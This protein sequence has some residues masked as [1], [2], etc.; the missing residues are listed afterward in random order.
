MG[1]LMAP[2]KIDGM[3]RATASSGPT[4]PEARRRSE[5]K[6]LGRAV[7][8]VVDS[9]RSRIVHRV[10]GVDLS[11]LGIRVRAEIALLPG[12]LVTVI[13]SEGNS[14]AVRSR[15]VW[16]GETGSERAGEAGI[17]FLEPLSFQA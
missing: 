16:V 1:V 5:R 15:V 3:V 9:E 10:F 8:L 11:A 2:K 4:P 7:S 17:A 12:Q 14:Q 6:P 13:P